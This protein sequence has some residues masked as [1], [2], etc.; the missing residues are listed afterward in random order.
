[1]ARGGRVFVEPE[2]AQIHAQI[3][4]IWPNM[5]NMAK[6][7]KNAYLGAYLGAQ[8][9]V[10]WGVP[11]KI[12]QNAVQT[13]WSIGPTSQKLGPNQIFGQ[14]PHCNYIGKLKMAC[15]IAFM[16]L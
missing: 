1:M 16:G 14:F 9:I 5:R 2:F 15:T 7:A 4:E 3:C 10:K 11:E 8:N 6:Y 13:R 12:M